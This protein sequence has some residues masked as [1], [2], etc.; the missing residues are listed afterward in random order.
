MAPSRASWVS[1]GV[2]LGLAWSYPNRRGENGPSGGNP[3]RWLFQAS[4]P[5]LDM[6]KAMN[7]PNMLYYALIFLLVGLLAGALGFL[8]LAGIAA[9]I[10]RV[11]FVLFLVLFLLSLAR[12]RRL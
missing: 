11:L 2:W 10:A 12:R 8:A 4:A 1:A 3:P 7:Q 6:G 5:G 9:L